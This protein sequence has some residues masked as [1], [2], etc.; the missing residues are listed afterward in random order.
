MKGVVWKRGMKSVLIEV[1]QH[2]FIGQGEGR[3]ALRSKRSRPVVQFRKIHAGRAGRA[4]REQAAMQLK[5]DPDTAH[6]LIKSGE[7]EM[8]RRCEDSRIVKAVPLQ[9]GMGGQGTEHGCTS[10]CWA[11]CCISAVG[12]CSV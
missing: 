6:L 7:V 2:V 3:Y 8:I 5:T 10:H 4:V 1:P 9:Q 11:S 12:G